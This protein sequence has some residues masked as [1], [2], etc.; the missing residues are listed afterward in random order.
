MSRQ[1]IVMVSTSYRY[2]PVEEAQA[3][4]LFSNHYNW[5]TAAYTY[6][7]PKFV[8][9][10]VDPSPQSSSS[11]SDENPFEIFTEY[12]RLNRKKSAPEVIDDE[13]SSDDS[14]DYG[15]EE[16]YRKTDINQNQRGV[17][18]TSG[19]EY[20][21]KFREAL[22]AELNEDQSRKEQAKLECISIVWGEISGR[23]SG[24]VRMDKEEATEINLG[25]GDNIEIFHN[26]SRWKA[27]GVVYEVLGNQ[28]VR[29]IVYNNEPVPL[30]SDD[31]KI[32]EHYEILFLFNDI[33]YKR[34]FL[35]L[36]LVSE[37]EVMDMH[38]RDRILGDKE[39]PTPLEG[40]LQL[41]EVPS[42]T[43][44]ESQKDAV[45]ACFFSCFVL[46]QGP[47]GTG[48]T[49]TSAAI[50]YN[51]VKQ[52]KEKML[53]CASSNVAVGNL[54]QRLYNCGINVL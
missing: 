3:S 52:R 29:F 27:P 13:S 10:S 38:L 18:Q 28:L 40:Q 25:R 46:I 24:K 5:D 31:K 16:K 37:G 41:L 54:A 26:D 11:E 20:E 15:D 53:I 8:W 39:E 50:V 2:V 42:V 51:I 49:S 30:D 47:P 12:E 4:Y 22:L 35:A 36:R 6:Q 48:K 33:T 19:M 43:L 1:K 34:M 9:S 17:G 21:E 7:P 45:K 32:E 23:L 44:N 14:E